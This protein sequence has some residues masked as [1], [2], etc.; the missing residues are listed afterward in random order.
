MQH[1]RAFLGDDRDVD[2]VVERWKARLVTL[3]EQAYSRMNVE[4]DCT[5]RL[6]QEL[7]F[8]NKNI[9]MNENNK[10]DNK[11]NIENKKIK[12]KI[13]YKQHLLLLYYFHLKIYFLL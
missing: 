3:R 10:I 7:L 1:C 11:F 5:I 2:G 9:G 12:I 13:I 6:L 8:E 4:F